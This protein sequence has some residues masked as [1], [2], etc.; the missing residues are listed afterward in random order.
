MMNLTAHAEGRLR[1][2]GI[3]HEVVDI[4]LDFG[5]AIPNNGATV[6]HM[7][8]KALIRYLK[9]A[10]PPDLQIVS[11][12]KKTYLIERDGRLLTVAHKK[13]CWRKKLTS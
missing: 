13:K 5:S 8:K 6:I 11:K 7:D 2:R 12:L 3:R 4:I 10:D 9:F 1:Q